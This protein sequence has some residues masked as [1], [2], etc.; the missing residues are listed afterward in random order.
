MSATV[1]EQ[2]AG[3]RCSVGRCV[4]DRAEVGVELVQGLAELLAAAVERGGERVE[5]GV[6]VGGS[7]R[8]QQR[9]QVGQ[10]LAQLDVGVDP[11]GRDDVAV[12]ERRLATGSSGGTNEMNF[13]PNSVVGRISTSTL[14]GISSAASGSSAD[15]MTACSPSWSMLADLA[16]QGAV[17]PDVAELGELEAG[18][19]GLDGHHR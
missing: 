6:E 8:A 16:D 18:P 17:E 1:G 12:L 10:D 2:D 15:L 14:A 5:R 9:E 4:V 13:W 3:P 7:D 11:V 19:V